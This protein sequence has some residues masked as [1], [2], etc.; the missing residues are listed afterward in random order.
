MIN[1][2]FFNDFLVENLEF[3]EDKVLIT[4]NPTNNESKCPCCEEKSDKIHSRYRRKLLDLPM[5]DKS[6]KIIL[7]SRRFFCNNPNCSRKI[8]SEQFKGFITRYKRTI[9]RLSNYLFRLGLSQSASQA[10]RLLGRLIPI[11]VSSILRIVKNHSINVSY[12]AEHVGI[13]DFSFKKGVTFGT[14]ICNLKS[15]KPI[16][17]IDSRNLDEVTEHLKL[18]KNAKIVSRDRSTTYARAINDAL[19]NVSQIA[20]FLKRYIGKAVKINKNIN[21]LKVAKNISEPTEK[22]EQRKTVDIEDKR[23]SYEWYANKRN[24]KKNIYFKKYC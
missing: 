23:T 14:I 8:F 7:N 11:S 5:L 13:D 20:D 16:D 18:Y 15:G 1:E 24:C 3:D 17:L 9:K 2:A 4:L 22:S 6:T 21:K 12:D 19:P 10:C